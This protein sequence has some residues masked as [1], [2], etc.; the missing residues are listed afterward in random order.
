MDR[1]FYRA[2]ENLLDTIDDVCAAA[3]REK[4]PEA[5]I[6]ADMLRTR[7]APARE[8]AAEIVKTPFDT[9]VKKAFGAALLKTFDK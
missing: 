4:D 8:V 7:L 5:K 1:K 3:N 2:T 9:A 6:L